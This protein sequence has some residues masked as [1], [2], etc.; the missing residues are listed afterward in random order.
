MMPIVEELEKELGDK[1]IFG[2]LN[3]DEQRELAI[4]YGIS[5][6]PAF[7]FVKNNQVVGKAIGSMNKEALKTKIQESLG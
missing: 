4:K 6:I 2:K 3:V 5:S 1:Y 7:V